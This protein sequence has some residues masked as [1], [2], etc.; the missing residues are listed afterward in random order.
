MYVQQRYMNVQQRYM[1]VQQRYINVQQRYMYVQQRYMYVQQ[2]IIKLIA[3][4]V[5]CRRDCP[6]VP[7]KVSRS[8]PLIL[9]NALRTLVPTNTAIA[10]V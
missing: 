1:N 8:I 9:P 5:K 6:D 10:A 3:E 7:N 4:N 2:R